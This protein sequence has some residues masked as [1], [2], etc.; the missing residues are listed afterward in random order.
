VIALTAFG[1]LL[2]GCSD[3]DGITQNDVNNL[4]GTWIQASVT[5]N[6]VAGDLADVLD[7]DSE[8]VEG[9]IA[10]YN[11]YTYTANELNSSD[12]PVYSESGTFEIDDNWLILTTTTVNDSTVTPSQAFNGKWATDGTTLTLTQTVG[13][14]TMVI[15]LNRPD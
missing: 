3:D 13:T 14:D 11:T 8:A 10:F 6:G 7:W 2:T 12:S 5:V 15:T 9:Q 4:Y 1:I